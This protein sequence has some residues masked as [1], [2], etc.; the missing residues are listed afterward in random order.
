M[1]RNLST[2]LKVRTAIRPMD[3]FDRLP[4]E[5]RRWL[6]SAALPWSARSVLRLWH[7]LHAECG[8]DPARITARLDRAER[9]MLERDRRGVWGDDYPSFGS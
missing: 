7:R 5:A 9:R 8:G 2:S 6:A 3:R 1:S 4:P